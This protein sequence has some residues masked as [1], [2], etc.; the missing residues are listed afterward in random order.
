MGSSSSK[1]GSTTNTAEMG[2]L[3]RQLEIEK[4]KN[5]VQASEITNLKALDKQAERIKKEQE[6][7]YLAKEQQRKKE[8]DAALQKIKVENS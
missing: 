1:R 7:K 5:A 4:Q 6:A 3:K 2:N 8:S